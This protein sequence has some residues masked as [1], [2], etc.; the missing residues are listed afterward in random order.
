MTTSITDFPKNASPSFV[1]LVRLV[2]YA[3]ADPR[4]TLA[5]K[6]VLTV[7]LLGHF[8]LQCGKAWPALN[9][10][11]VETNLSR[12]GVRKSI[13]QLESNGYLWIKR[14][15]GKTSSRYMVGPTI[16]RVRGFPPYPS[17]GSPRIPK[18]TKGTGTDL[19][20][21]RKVLAL[22]TREVRP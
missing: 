17:E 22:G 12:I 20:A 5:A 1:E 16:A 14:G 4:L 2:A 7:I 18:Q 11:A 9:T 8:N 21:Q 10:L 13:K 3:Q 19:T 6:S 15:K